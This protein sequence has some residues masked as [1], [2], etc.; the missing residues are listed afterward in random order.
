MSKSEKLPVSAAKR[1]FGW[2]ITVIIMLVVYT[3]THWIEEI[4][5][6]IGF[7]LRY[8]IGIAVTAGSWGLFVG[9]LMLGEEFDLLGERRRK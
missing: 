6:D 2:V 7:G 9:L 3:V 4:W 1:F 8:L 5:F